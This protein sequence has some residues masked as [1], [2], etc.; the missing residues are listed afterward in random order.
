MKFLLIL[1]FFIELYAE[2]NPL[3]NNLTNINELSFNCD[4]GQSEACLNLAK[5]YRMK[6]NYAKAAFF[7]EKACDLKD[8]YGCYNLGLIYEYGCGI[9]GFIDYEKAL[10]LYSKACILGK[11]NNEACKVMKKF[12]KC[13]EEENCYQRLETRIVDCKI[14]PLEYGGLE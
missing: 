7:Y 1:L 2:S 11:N 3:N 9:E 6:T 4:I 5:V 14:L 8:R 10:S 12:K 13:I